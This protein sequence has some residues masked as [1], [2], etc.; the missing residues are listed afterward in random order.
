MRLIGMT[1]HFSLRDILAGLEKTFA[2]LPQFVLGVSIVR[3]G[4]SW[5]R[6]A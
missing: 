5:L 1:T 4:V 2:P 3:R 6:E